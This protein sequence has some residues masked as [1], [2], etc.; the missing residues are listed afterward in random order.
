K[1]PHFP[2]QI[3]LRGL[4][5]MRTFHE[6]DDRFT[7]PLHGF[8]SARHYW[9]SC[10]SRHFL[11]RIRIPA[12]LVNAADDPFLP[13]ACYPHRELG[14]GGVVLEV[15]RWGGHVGFM[16]RDPQGCYWSERRVLAFLHQHAP[17]A[18]TDGSQIASRS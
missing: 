10:S 5:R 16:S 11:G 12:L 13:A 18:T 6:F 3:D 17:L 2:D 15:P 14:R 7:A 4:E 9:E 1:H 8:R